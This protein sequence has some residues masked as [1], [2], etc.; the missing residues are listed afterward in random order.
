M[1]KVA[2]WLRFQHA[3][4]RHIG[5][6]SDACRLLMINGFHHCH[7]GTCVYAQREAV[8]QSVSH[9]R[10]LIRFSGSFKHAVMIARVFYQLK[11]SKITEDD[12]LMADIRVEIQ[13]DS[14]SCLC[15]EWSQPVKQ[16]QQQQKTKKKISF[17][18]DSSLQNE[19]KNPSEAPKEPSC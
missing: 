4:S 9:R 14:L 10:Q 15:L 13:H 6:R 7:T 3:R 1:K 19:P 12:D 8:S 11:I 18:S 17:N 5:W 16:Q 2:D